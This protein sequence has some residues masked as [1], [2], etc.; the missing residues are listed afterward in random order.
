MKVLKFHNRA[1]N[2]LL[3]TSSLTCK[4]HCVD[5]S[6]FISEVSARHSH[7][8]VT[9]DDNA[10][11]ANAGLAWLYLVLTHF[12]EKKGMKKDRPSSKHL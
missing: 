1:P 2:L 7:L 8:S 3:V 9:S 12:G 10:Q 4:N 6:R 5:R 11:R